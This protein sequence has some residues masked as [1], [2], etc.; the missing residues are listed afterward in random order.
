VSDLLKRKEKVSQLQLVLFSDFFCSWHDFC[1]EFTPTSELTKSMTQN[2][3]LEATTSS[4]NQE[5]PHISSF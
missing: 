2:N 5:I 3:S 1:F 4:S